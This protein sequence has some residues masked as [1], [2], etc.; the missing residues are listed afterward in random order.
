[1]LCGLESTQEFTGKKN[2]GSAEAS[3]FV[4]KKMS[5]GNVGKERKLQLTLR[6]EKWLTGYSTC[7]PS[8]RTRV[9]ILITHVKAR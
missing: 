8:K 1:M 5:R 6:L 3:L 4:L 7:C 2:M 9:Q